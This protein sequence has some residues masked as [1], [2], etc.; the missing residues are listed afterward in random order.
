[1]LEDVLITPNPRLS[2]NTNTHYPP[3]GAEDY[4]GDDDDEPRDDD[5]NMALLGTTRDSA[6][7]LKEQ[8]SAM[9]DLKHIVFE[10]SMLVSVFAAR[11]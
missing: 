8:R 4:E 2:G 6:Y 3:L 9:Y 7:E 1:M 10:V 11:I 5:G